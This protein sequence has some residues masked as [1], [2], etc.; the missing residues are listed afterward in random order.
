M[1]TP[2]ACWFYGA[3]PTFFFSWGGS[4]TSMGISQLSSDC[5]ARGIESHCF[6]FDDVAGAEQ[7][8]IP[9]VR[10]G[11]PLI[12]GGYSLGVTSITYLQTVYPTTL[13][14]ALAGST[15]GRNSAINHHNT[16]RSVAWRDPNSVLSG[17]DAKGL[18]FDIIHDMTGVL[19]LL[20]D[21]SP[22]VASGV[23]DE[24]EKFLS[25]RN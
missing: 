8:I 20:F 24:L 9:A 22:T 3:G 5:E 25:E 17:F 6:R 19:H 11:C 14:L 10:I 23:I 21:F 2:L 18:G 4:L 7:F 12:L 13:L 16:N 1:K 15:L